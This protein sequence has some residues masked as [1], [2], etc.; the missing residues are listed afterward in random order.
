MVRLEVVEFGAA[1][2]AVALG[3]EIA[4]V[5]PLRAPGSVGRS[6]SSKDRLASLACATKAGAALD[7]GGFFFAAATGRTG[8]VPCTRSSKDRLAS[9]AQSLSLLEACDSLS[10]PLWP[11]SSTS[12]SD[13]SMSSM[14]V[15]SCDA[16]FGG[17]CRRAC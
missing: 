2:T 13:E 1:L 10:S 15:T 14:Q 3:D 16:S 4:F 17:A 5:K 12:S 9:E 11:E 6:K 7:F 8:S